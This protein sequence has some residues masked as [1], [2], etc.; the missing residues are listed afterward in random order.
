MPLALDFIQL[1]LNLLLCLVLDLL[2]PNPELPQLRLSVFELQPLLVECQL[3]QIRL[4]PLLPDFLF[5]RVLLLLYADEPVHPVGLELFLFGLEGLELRNDPCSVILLLHVGS[6]LYPSNLHVYLVGVEFVVGEELSLA[7][8]VFKE[9]VLGYQEGLHFLSLFHD[10]LLCLLQFF[11]FLEKVIVLRGQVLQ[12]LD[13]L[14]DL[15][16]FN[17][18]AIL[19][20]LN[21]LFE[22]IDLQFLGM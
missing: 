9:L 15:I 16:T 11:V 14:A 3:H 13:L 20:L 6:V 22:P 1:R 4:L 10:I 5:K 8:Y 18:Q 21:E 19:P 17:C 2:L 7:G 12:M